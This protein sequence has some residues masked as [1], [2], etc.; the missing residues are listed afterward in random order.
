MKNKIKER[1]K[2]PSFKTREKKESGRKKV[3]SIILT[4]WSTIW[5]AVAFALCA[6]GGSEVFIWWNENFPESFP[7]SMNWMRR[8]IGGEIGAVACLL[9]IILPINRRRKRKK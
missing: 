8:I 6:L 1:H 2:L 9:F 4:A 7:V 3:W 5:P